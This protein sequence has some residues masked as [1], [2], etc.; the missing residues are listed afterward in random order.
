MFSERL[1]KLRISRSLSQAELADMLGI[2]QQTVAKWENSSTSPKPATLKR[3]TEIFDV[4]SDY[5]LDI[6][7]KICDK[8]IIAALFG[9]TDDITDE[10]YE[11]VKKFAAFLIEHNKKGKEGSRWII[12]D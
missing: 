11:D 3:L 8:D 7:P 9:E 1:K 12:S 6:P 10:M 2:S 4:T 5:L